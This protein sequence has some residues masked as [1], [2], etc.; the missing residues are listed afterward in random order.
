MKI[1]VTLTDGTVAEFK[2]MHP[3]RFSEG[4]LNLYPKDT[5]REG[6]SYPVHRIWLVRDEYET[7]DEQRK[8]LQ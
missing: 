5:N 7:A 6:W 8:I 2:G 1:R 3:P 4:W